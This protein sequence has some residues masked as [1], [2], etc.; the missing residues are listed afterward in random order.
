MTKEK[1]DKLGFIKIRKFYV[2][3]DTIKKV[4]CTEDF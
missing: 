2:S 1:V 4:K 3:K